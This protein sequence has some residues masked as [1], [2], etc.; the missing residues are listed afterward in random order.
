MEVYD[1]AYK[2][3][4]EN[5]KHLK[6]LYLEQLP[7]LVLTMPHYGFEISQDV[8]DACKNA[9]IDALNGGVEIE[10]EN[11]SDWTF[12]E[13]INPSWFKDGYADKLK[14]IA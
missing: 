7:G 5:V 3:A 9:I 8:I 6:H 13:E 11:E 12:W 4:C 2:I 10:W 14:S 1:K